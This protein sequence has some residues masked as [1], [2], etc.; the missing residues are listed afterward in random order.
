MCIFVDN[1]NNLYGST[2]QEICFML[3]FLD[4]AKIDEIRKYAF[5]LHGVTTTP[6][7][8]KRDSNMTSDEFMTV[9]RQEFP[10]LE[11]HVEAMAETSEETQ[12][13]IVDE[14][15]K[16][17]WYDK[18]KVV[19]KVPIS[20]DGLRTTIE[21]SKAN[22]DVRINLHMAFAAGQAALA[23]HA[24]PAYIAPLIGRYADKV[25]ELRSNGKRSAADD[26]GLDMLAE[27]VACKE[28]LESDTHIL[29]S[30][31]RSVHD[32]AEAIK[33]GADAATLPPAILAEALE[34]PM[35]TEGV[36]VFK[37]DLIALG[38]Y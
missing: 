11:I 8:I 10:E 3:L 20:L 12:K 16:K 1:T 36:E 25:A 18:D 35:T 37:K 28:S 14:F 33:M 24:K 9:V 19:F 29:T 30:S 22:P 34:H 31:I 6:T 26:A 21:L 17:A 5:M 27:V 15:C 7:I 38:E 2:V 23:M 13:L 4:T 32:F